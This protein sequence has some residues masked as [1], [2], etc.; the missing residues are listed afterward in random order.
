MRAHVHGRASVWRPRHKGIK[1]IKTNPGGHPWWPSGGE[2]TN[3]R[4]KH[5]L[6]PWPGRMPQ[7][8]LRSSCAHRHPGTA[9]LQPRS[10]ATTAPEPHTR[11]STLQEGPPHRSRRAAPLAATREEKAP[12]AAKTQHTQNKN[13]WMNEWTEPND[14]V[15]LETVNRLT[16][17]KSWQ[18]QTVENVNQSKTKLWRVLKVRQWDAGLIWKEEV[19]SSWRF[20][21]PVAATLCG[22]QDYEAQSK[23]VG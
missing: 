1:R 19:E 14:Q 2:S 5:R 23:G 21:N 3:Q 16:R 9:V 11:E 20:S 10:S 6:D 17:A 7:A 8:M 13:E 15:S 4:R 12:A 18:R 22:P